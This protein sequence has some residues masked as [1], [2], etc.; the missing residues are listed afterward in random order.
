[1][2]NPEPADASMGEAQ[3]FVI[4]SEVTCSDGV[5]GELRRVVVDPIARSLTHL[6]VE[7]KHRQGLGRLVP[8]Q[9]VSSGNGAITLT[10]TTAQFNALERA[11]ETHFM[12]GAGSPWGY[13]ENQVLTQP[14]S[15][16]GV[17]GLGGLGGV[18]GL[19]TGMAGTRTPIVV[20]RVP[21]GEVEVRRGES[22]I[23]TDGPIGKVAGLAVDPTDHYVTHV[24]LDEG[25]LWGKKTVAIPI[26]A[27]KRIEGGVHLDLSKDDVRDLP[28]VQLA[29]A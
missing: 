17:A 9:L 29:E 24:L 1:M 5:C 27:V 23:A 10:C 2:T 19:A 21:A 7:E 18:G 28:P 25:H 8:I 6:V 4:G 16:L 13:N 26:G 20:D 3:P 15:A 11:E 22:V 12:A 14:Y